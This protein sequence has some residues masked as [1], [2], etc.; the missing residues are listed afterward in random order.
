MDGRAGH[1][2]QTMGILS[3]LDGL[4]PVSVSYYQVRQQSPVAMIINTL[5][6]LLPAGGPVQKKENADTIDLIIGT[7]SRTH[8]AMLDLKKQCRRSQQ[9]PPRAATCMSPAF[10][11]TSGFDLIAAPL[12][13]R[14][15]RGDNILITVG[16]PNTATFSPDH[17]ISKGLILLG[18]IDPKSHNWDEKRIFDMCRTICT[19]HPLEWT[20]SS[21]PRT[22]DSTCALFE[23][24]AA[25]HADI[26]FFRAENTVPGW[27]EEEY[28]KNYYT[29]VTADSVSMVYEALSAGC[30]VGVLP[31]DWKRK[32]NKFERSL[33]HLRNNKYITSYEEWRNGSVLRPAHPPLNEAERCA[34][35]ILNRW[36]PERL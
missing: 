14:P 8:L 30:A 5:K 33:Q 6:L 16:P 7:G 15:G 27:I 20:I 29:W 22:P 9:R 35:E 13:D 4:T 34:R 18:G 36:W 12:H 11:L 25:N 3:V 2:K 1:E 10:W 26:Y 28:Q 21:S 32:N 23:E 19:S 24:L 31:V 17:D